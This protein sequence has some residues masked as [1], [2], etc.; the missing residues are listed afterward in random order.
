MKIKTTILAGIT[1][2]MLNTGLGADAFAQP[3]YRSRDRYVERDYRSGRNWRAQQVVRQ[4]YID[5][6]RR[7]PDR[8]GLRQYTDAIVHR[9]WS[10]ADVRRSLLRSDEYRQNFGR[11]GYRAYRRYR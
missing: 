1:G 4:A 11:G 7:E 10:Q 8:S 5:I 3:V 9:G 2:L 6:L